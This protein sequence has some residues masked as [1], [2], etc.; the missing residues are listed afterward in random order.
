MKVVNT[1]DLRQKQAETEPSSTN[2]LLPV[3]TGVGWIVFKPF[4]TIARP[5]LASSLLLFSDKVDE[6]GCLSG[7]YVRK[8][9]LYSE[10][11]SE[12]G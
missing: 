2:E 10:R 1:A 11:E 12:L 3:M 9:T 8:D 6:L 4:S 7:S 5:I